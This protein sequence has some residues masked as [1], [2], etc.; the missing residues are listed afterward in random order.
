MVRKIIWSANAKANRIEILDYWIK[1]IN[2]TL[3]V[4]N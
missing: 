3:T 4:K 2:P 1:E